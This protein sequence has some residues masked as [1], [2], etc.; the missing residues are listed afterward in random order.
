MPVS[1]PKAAATSVSPGAPQTLTVW[2]TELLSPTEG[3]DRSRIFE[4]QILAFEATHPGLTVQVLHKAPDGKG[5]M[6]DLLATA[7]TAAPGVIPDLI[8]IDTRN[9][10]EVARKGLV[11]PL[12]AF[13]SPSLQADL[14]PFAIAA[15]TVDGQ[16]VGVQFEVSIQHAI[17]NT[18][19]IAVAPVTWEEVFASGAT[20]TFP[21]AGQDGLV[22]DAFLIQY[23]ST[24]VELMDSSG[25]PYLDRQALTEALEFYRQ[26]IE[27]GAIPS[28]V[29]NYATVESGWPKYLQAEVVMTHISSKLYLT[30][31]DSLPGHRPAAIPT[32]DGQAVALSR[33][34]AW[35]VTSRD[36]NRQVLA[37]KLLEWLMNPVNMAAW[38]Q[39]ASYLPTRRAVFEQMT[40]DTYVSFVYTQLEHAV[41]YRSSEAHQRIYRAMQQAVDAVLR[42]GVLPTVAAE[43]VLKA[44]NQ[45]SL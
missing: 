21:T 19:K 17:Y 34:T 2:I 28:E 30:G 25:D 12:D 43:N 6:Q 8:A 15:G 22:N 18:S 44:I 40:R 4:Q 3:G 5:G 7:S 45:E 11:V 23:L 9:L 20:Y 42:E 35:A 33:G 32:R 14:Y 41:P 26:G 10:E 24:G 38:S 31:P 36:P 1:T 29:L 39:A 27:N 37:I 16:L 13:L